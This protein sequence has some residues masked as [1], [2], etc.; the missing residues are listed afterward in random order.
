MKNQLKIQLKAIIRKAN[1][2][3]RIAEEHYQ[4]GDYD[5]ASSKAYYAVFYL[6]EAILLTRNLTFSKHSAVISAFNQYFIR[7][8]IFPK[9]FGKMIGNLFRERQ[10]GDYSY[11]NSPSKEE[12]ERDLA[13]A[14]K[15]SKDIK[16]FLEKVL[17]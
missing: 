3:L 13:D 16:S 10:V 14:Q 5:F 8:G 7:E 4:R 6:M 17:V 11:V 1:R 2:A 12:A 15:I 9:E